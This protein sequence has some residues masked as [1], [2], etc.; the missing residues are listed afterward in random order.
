M[1]LADVSAFWLLYALGEGVGG[2]TLFVG[3]GHQVYMVI[4]MHNIAQT[5]SKTVMSY[6]I[7]KIGRIA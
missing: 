7:H 6:E 4:M 5:C 2:S 1:F 3:D